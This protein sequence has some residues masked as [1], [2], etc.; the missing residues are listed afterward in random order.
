MARL[1]ISEDGQ[2]G[3][4]RKRGPELLL[5]GVRGTWALGGATPPG[6]C[7]PALLGLLAGPLFQGPTGGS[8]I[9]SPASHLVL[10]LVLVLLWLHQ[11]LAQ[12]CGEIG[13]GVRL[14]GAGI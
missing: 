10:G 13:E 6:P 9:Q 1:L 3:K 7:P 2:E 14:G 8:L 5:D 12:W 4:G 11:W